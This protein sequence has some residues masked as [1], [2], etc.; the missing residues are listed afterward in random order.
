[1]KRAIEPEARLLVVDDEP[2]IRELLSTS[3]RFAGFEVHTAANGQ[4]AL[5]QAERTRPDL[6]VLD[7]MMPDLD[8]FAVTRRLR[9]RGRDTPVLFLTAKDDVTDR[10]AGLTVGGD[11]YV[12]KPFSLEEVVARIRAILRRTGAGADPAAGRLVFHDLALD[13]DSHEVRRAGRPID[14]SPTEFKLLRY[15]MLNPNRVLSK[16]QILDHVWDY[17]FRGE[18]GIVESY[19]SYLRRKV[20]A[21]PPEEGPDA[22]QPVPLIHTKRGVGYVLR[23]PPE[24]V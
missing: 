20:D 6:L 14:L 12:T 21:P 10:V 22:A 9:E 8:G 24:G 1:V 2:N 18:A 23:L 7:V 19:I 11:D 3:L 17:D 13:E 5:S 15:L 4:E 16:A